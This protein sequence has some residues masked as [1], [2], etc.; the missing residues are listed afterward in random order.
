MRFLLTKTGSLNERLG[1]LVSVVFGTISLVFFGFSTVE[2]ARG[3]LMPEE[4][5]FVLLP[6]F[7]LAA[8]LAQRIPYMLG[9]GMTVAI[10][11]FVHGFI[12]IILTQEPGNEAWVTIL[13]IGICVL[14]FLLA[15]L[16]FGSTRRAVRAE[17]QAKELTQKREVLAIE[18][19]GVPAHLQSQH[20]A[21]VL[22]AAPPVTRSCPYCGVNNLITAD[23]C[24]DCGNSITF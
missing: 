1:Y 2:L 5:G 3:E 17:Q 12:Q 13:G 15:S 19:R 4:Y 18:F 6:L 23:K 8:L 21:P 11:A 7:F 14:S 20:I 9:F 16:F 10:S 24:S 22:T